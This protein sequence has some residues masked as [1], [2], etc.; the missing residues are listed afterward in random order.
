MMTTSTTTISM[1]T[2]T[3]TSMTTLEGDDMSNLHSGD[4]DGVDIDELADGPEDEADEVETEVSEF[5]ADDTEDDEG[6]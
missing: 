1:T 6:L 4:L 3:M 5:G 2:T